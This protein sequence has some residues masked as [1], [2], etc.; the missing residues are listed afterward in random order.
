MPQAHATARSKSAIQSFKE[1]MESLV[2]AFVLAF[3]F[4]AFIVEAFVIPT[5][6]MADTL[7]GAHFRLVCPACSYEFNYG[8]SGSS[9]GVIP[10]QKIPLYRDTFKKRGVAVCP[11]CGTYIDNSQ[12]RWV[13]N[14]DRILVLKYLYQFVDPKIWDVV[15]FK[16]PTEPT[17]NYIKRLIGRPGQTV[18]IRDG[19]VYI[20]NQIQRK[21]DHVQDALWILAYHSDYQIPAGTTIHRETEIWDQPFR[22][23]SD[24]SS[25]TMDAQTRTF[26]FAGSVEPESLVFHQGRI[27]RFSQCFMS[28]NGL[29]NDDRCIASD[30]KLS[31]VL[32]PQEA[33]GRLSILLGK[34][35]RIYRGEIGFDGTVR[36][37][38]DT[39]GEVLQTDRWPDDLAAG[40]AVPISFVCVDHT[41]RLQVGDRRLS[42]IGLDDPA[43]WGYARKDRQYH[44]PSVALEAAGG[45]FALRQV[46]LYRDVHYTQH[47]INGSPGRGT[48]E[49]QPFQLGKDEFFV[50]GDN[51]PQS[52]DSRFWNEPGK[53][54]GSKPYPPGIVP[55]D[56]LIGR[57]FFVYWP[58]GFHLH[59]SIPYAVIP[60]VGD[61][62]FIH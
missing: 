36:I 22:S 42:Y 31:A 40:R 54:N 49:G 9:D 8:Y 35:D 57:A 33:D 3:I 53:S 47:D 59:S 56:Y 19:D 55:R 41:L 12:R 38:N 4:R 18:E 5:G 20:D 24:P 13:S 28:Y 16:N 52:H 14:G 32:T 7:R 44:L 2:I 60:N 50:L 51:S 10:K 34:Y 46:A 39:T 15:V 62:R 11:M 27:R 45:G 61:M 43:A 37:V 58:A 29:D 17:Q 21:P 1:T 25:W 48:E 6:S 23:G 30:L 26:R